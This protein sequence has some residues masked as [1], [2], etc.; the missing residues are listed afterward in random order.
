MPTSS[1][2]GAVYHPETL[3]RA[4]QAFESAWARIARDFEPAAHAEARLK[5]AGI[6]L[7]L[8]ADGE[9]SALELKCRA[10]GTMHAPET[11]RAK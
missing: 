1:T 10:I 9:S 8:A 11:N 6:V 4:G 3:K 7:Q 5:L 2:H